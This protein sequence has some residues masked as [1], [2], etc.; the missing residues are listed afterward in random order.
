MLE[1]RLTADGSV[2]FYSRRFGEPY[3][4]VTAGAFAEAR[5][6]FCVPCGVPFKAKEGELNILDVCFGMGYNTVVALEL[7]FSSNP[8]A[9]VRVVAVDMDLRP[10]KK[11]LELDWG[12]Y[13]RWKGVL[14]QLTNSRLCGERFPVHFYCRKNLEITLFIG[15]CRAVLKEVSVRYSGFAD[16]VFHDPFSPKV[17]PELWTCEFFGLLKRM[18][19]RD[20]ILATYSASSAV[21]KALLLAGFGVKEGVALG[22]R[23]K[24]TVASLCWV[25]DSDLLRKILS[26]PVAPYRDPGL[27]GTPEEI[28]LRKR[29]C[30]NIKSWD[31]CG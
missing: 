23:S 10:A 29:I 11:A 27:C 20:A 4:S 16:A 26:S 22:R 28:S 6:K 1:R 13:S 25:T 21:R 15:E 7:A 8:M 14:R 18:M 24:S 12:Y 17:N 19:K 3:H 2:T 5:E 9:K 30:D 31:W